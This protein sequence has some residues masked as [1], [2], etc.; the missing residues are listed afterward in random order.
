M[1]IFC[2]LLKPSNTKFISKRENLFKLIIFFLIKLKFFLLVKIIIM[3]FILISPITFS[4]SIKNSWDIEPLI[5]IYVFSK[6]IFFSSDINF[7]VI[8]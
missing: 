2:T 3:G 6:F 4:N 7:F 1:I 5:I 8:T